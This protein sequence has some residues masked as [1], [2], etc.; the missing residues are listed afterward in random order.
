MS[1]RYTRKYRERQNERRCER[2][3]ESPEY[4]LIVINRTRK[5]EGREPLASVEQA[6]IRVPLEGVRA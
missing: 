6:K 3:R 5:R 2:Y 4:R 1:Y